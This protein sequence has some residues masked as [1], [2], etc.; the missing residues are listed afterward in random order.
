MKKSTLLTMITATDR[1][2]QTNADP[3]QTQQN[4]AYDRGLHYLIAPDRLFFPPKRYFCYF[5]HK[6]LLWYSL[7]VPQ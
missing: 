3:D 2:Q 5:S 1:P 6:C 4:A 7:E